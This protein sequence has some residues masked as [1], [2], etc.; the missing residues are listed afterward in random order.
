MAQ[1]GSKYAFCLCDGTSNEQSFCGMSTR[2]L[3][4]DFAELYVTAA[5]SDQGIG[6]AAERA[7]RALK[8][9]WDSRLHDRWHCEDVLTRENLRKKLPPISGGVRSLHLS[10]VFIGGLYDLKHQELTLSQ[11]GDCT[12][13]IFFKNRSAHYIPAN[14]D[15]IVVWL[16]LPSDSDPVVR[17]SP[18]FKQLSQMGFQ[19]VDGWI[20]LTDG[21]ENSERLR[22]F[23]ERNQH[24]LPD[25]IYKLRSLRADTADD[26]GLVTA[27]HPDSPGSACLPAPPAS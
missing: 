11:A 6:T 4:Q 19:D 13:W 25:L 10:F 15:R 23:I 16:D 24:R 12:G 1:S 3:A 22:P 27:W 5:L 14:S 8:H 9:E 7:S 18:K 17:L 26:R 20:L 21:V 2:R